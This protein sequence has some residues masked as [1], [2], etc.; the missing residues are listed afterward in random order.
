MGFFPVD[1]ETLAYL[2][3]TGRTGRRSSARRTLHKE[4]GLFR[5][6]QHT[7]ANISRRTVELRSLDRRAEPRWAK[8]TSRSHARLSRDEI[9]LGVV[10]ST[11]CTANIRPT[12]RPQGR[13]PKLRLR[14]AVAVARSRYF[15]GVEVQLA[16]DS[17]QR[18]THGARSSIAAITSCTNTSQPLGD[19]RCGAGRQKGG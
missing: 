15:D 3:R 10:T 7:R 13:G 6:D 11:R 12:V 9:D 16:G 18:F 5:T 17:V 2:R 8:T 19:D 4:Q 14:T 1:I